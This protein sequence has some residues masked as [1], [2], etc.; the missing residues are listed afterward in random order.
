MRRKWFSEIKFRKMLVKH[1]T[2]RVSPIGI[3]KRSVCTRTTS[4]PHKERYFINN[5]R[6]S[7]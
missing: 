4:K 7:Y 2:L 6:K 5:A 1:L 3:L